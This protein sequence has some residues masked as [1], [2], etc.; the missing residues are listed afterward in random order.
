MRVAQLWLSGFRSYEELSL[1][2]PPGLTAIVGPNG[3]GK[4]NILEAIGWL[5]SMRSFRG[6]GNDA[7]VRTD[8][9]AAVARAEVVAGDRPTMIEAEIAR[10]GRSR[11]LVN[12]QRLPR[13]RDLVG[14]LRVTV[15]SP[16]DL[17]LVKGAP[18]VRREWLDDLLVASNPRNDRL[19]TE[20]ERVLRQRNALLKQ[21]G[22]RLVPEV[23]A[24]LDV[25]DHK[26]AAA[27]DALGEVRAAALVEL[28][29][30]ITAAYR[31]IAGG[32]PDRAAVQVRYDAA[33]RGPGLAEELER[34]RRDD[35]RRGT[36]TVGPHRDEVLLA[37]DAL[38]ART[39]RSQGEQRSLALALQLAAHRWVTRVTGATPVLLLDD[40][41]SELD[42]RRCRA[43][44]D[45]LPA[46][47]TLLT[48]AVGVPA[49]TAPELVV[50]VLD[51]RAVARGP[52]A[53]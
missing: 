29:D 12:R 47:Q 27:G 50:D 15:F 22:G 19:R 20:F 5:A 25:W 34:A 39:Q 49:G 45:E 6:A 42:E 46:V 28:T 1:E 30:E 48:S 37:V 53:G 43:L 40:V 36:T 33:W 4:T 18:A 31:R 21:A 8:A 41:F 3:Q 7:L 24:T 9:A 44:L 52:V 10:T 13:A 16:D 14:H 17:A 11:V 38:P 23:A 35:V 26:L 32:V 51:G 2:L